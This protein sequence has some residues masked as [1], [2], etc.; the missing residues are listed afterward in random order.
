MIPRLESTA[1]KLFLDVPREIIIDPEDRNKLYTNQNL[2]LE[3][4]DVKD[5]G[6]MLS[7]EDV[8]DK[9]YYLI[10]GMVANGIVY[11]LATLRYLKKIILFLYFSVANIVKSLT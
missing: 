11:S 7:R 1:R 4:Y 8:P 9:V 6:K 10:A 2:I 3:F 5:V